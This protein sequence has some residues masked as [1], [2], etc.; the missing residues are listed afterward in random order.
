MPAFGIEINVLELYE[1]HKMKNGKTPC[2]MNN[3][4]LQELQQIIKV[5]DVT[6]VANGQTPCP[7]AQHCVF[8]SINI[9]IAMWYQRFKISEPVVV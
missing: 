4:E 7:R 8:V 9:V 5:L 3:Y 1:S 2:P 6:E